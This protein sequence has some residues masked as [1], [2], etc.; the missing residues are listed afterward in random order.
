MTIVLNGERRE[1]PD[2]LSLAGLIAELGVRPAHVAV[3]RNSELVPRAR[4]A[5]TEL[6]E[7]D[8]EVPARR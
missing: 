2:G 8:Q 4:H 5:E 1:L 3:E 7:G 6:A